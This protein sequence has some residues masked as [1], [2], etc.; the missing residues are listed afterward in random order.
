MLSFLFLSASTAATYIFTAPNSTTIM[1]SLEPCALN[2][3][4]RDRGWKQA[5]RQGEVKVTLRITLLSNGFFPLQKDKYLISFFFHFPHGD[6]TQCKMY[7]G[8]SAMIPRFYFHLRCWSWKLRSIATSPSC[9]ICSASCS[10]HPTTTGSR[11]GE[12]TLYIYIY[13]IKDRNLST[14]STRHVETNVNTQEKT[15]AIKIVA[16]KIEDLMLKGHPLPQIS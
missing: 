1:I 14:I 7:M 12:K 16:K 6:F 3:E 11:N 9:W 2:A 4:Y 8:R 15:K 10:S 5:Q 13:I